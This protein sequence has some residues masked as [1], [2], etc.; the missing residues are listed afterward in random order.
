MRLANLNLMKS[1]SRGSMRLQ[2]VREMCVC[3]VQFFQCFQP[4]Q[5]LI[6]F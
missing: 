1:A 4:H 6:N 5:Q 2:F 3:V